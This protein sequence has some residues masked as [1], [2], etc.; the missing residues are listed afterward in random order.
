MANAN[1][2][3]QGTASEAHAS[4]SCETRVLAGF[5]DEWLNSFPKKLQAVAERLS[6]KT[7]AR[8]TNPYYLQTKNAFPVSVG[9]WQ[10][11]SFLIEED[12]RVS[13]A[14]GRYGTTLV[15][16]VYSV[17]AKNEEAS[18]IA[19]EAIYFAEG[20]MPRISMKR[21]KDLI[22]LFEGFFLAVDDQLKKDPSINAIT[23][24]TAEIYNLER[25]V[26][27][28][29]EFGFLEVPEPQKGTVHYRVKIRKGQPLPPQ[30]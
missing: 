7:S 12:L 28:L 6:R 5:D 9:F 26:P 23:L 22:E 10:L 18:R 25:V 3:P 17:R 24:K 2:E 21:A 30:Q 27:M 15:L 29:S 11:Q 4:T 8:E 19:G 14:I 16:Y 20:E 13:F 1:D